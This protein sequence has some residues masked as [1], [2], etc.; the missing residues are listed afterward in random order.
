MEE[1]PGDGS[2]F[3]EESD[4]SG[5]LGDVDGTCSGEETKVGVDLFGGAIGD[6]PVVQS[7]SPESSVAFGEVCGD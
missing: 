7:I 1:A 4:C 5:G 2:D 6:T 3:V